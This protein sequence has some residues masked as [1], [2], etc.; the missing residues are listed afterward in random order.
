MYVCETPCECWSLNPG[1]LEEQP[2]LLIA[3][4]S[5]QPLNQFLRQSY[6]TLAPAGLEITM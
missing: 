3:E 1:P 4:P 6:T 5:L 2:M